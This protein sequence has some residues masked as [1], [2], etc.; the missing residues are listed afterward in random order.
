MRNKNNNSSGNT[1]YAPGTTLKVDIGVYWHYG[2]AAGY[3][4]IIHLTKRNGSVVR[5]SYDDFSGGREILECAEITSDFPQEAVNRAL[6]Y[7]DKRY[8]L[9]NFNCEHFVRMCHGLEKESHQVQSA[10]IAGGSTLAM[11]SPHPM[12]KLAGAVF[13]TGASTPDPRKSPIEKG[14]FALGLFV[15]VGGI[16][17]ALLLEK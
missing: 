8:D 15:I 4:E 2:M 10:V 7:T 13:A 17:G 6:D 16:L 11:V 5:E 3:D 14:L 1:V 12:V 9:L